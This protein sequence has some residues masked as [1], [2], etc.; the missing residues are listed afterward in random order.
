[1]VA[2]S[3]AQVHQN[4]HQVGW[5]L[6]ALSAQCGYIVPL[7]QEMSITGGMNARPTILGMAQRT[8]NSVGATKNAA[9]PNKK[10]NSKRQCKI[11]AKI[12]RDQT[13]HSLP[14]NSTFYSH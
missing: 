3:F 12:S 6:T 1:V 8:A 11:F 10:L 13:S 2:N 4:V 9:T 14:I 5:D 7:K